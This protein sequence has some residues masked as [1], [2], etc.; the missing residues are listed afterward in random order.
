MQQIE[1][2]MTKDKI[3]AVLRE[4]ILDGSFKPGQK[5]VEKELSDVLGVSRTPLREAIRMLEVEGIVESIPNKGSRVAQMTITDIINIY[6][7]RIH[8]E[9]LAVKKAVPY[10]TEDI[11][12]NLSSIQ[13]E[14]RLAVENNDWGM[15]DLL[16]R[17]FHLSFFSPGPN[18]R[19]IT[20]VEQLH[21]IGRIIR[22]SA[23]SIPGRGLKVLDEHEEI[24]KYAKAGDAEQAG[25]WMKRH[26][27]LAKETLLNH[28]ENKM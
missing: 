1:Q 11:F 23:F 21:Q 7:L 26:L 5:L 3:V 4:K 22:I 2:V 14:I 18:D 10:L 19:L 24:L 20:M 15:V 16:N 6:E 9:S 27:E 12:N 28:I 8:L 25:E 17:K 13:D